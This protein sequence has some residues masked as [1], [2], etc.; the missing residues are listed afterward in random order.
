MNL[1]GVAIK[2]LMQKNEVEPKDLILVYD[3]L[4]LPWGSLRL[5]PDGSAAG[6]NGV[7]DVIDKIGTPA[8]PRVR[9]GVHPG[10]RL[11]QGTGADYLLS[12]FSRQQN[13]TLD[14]FVSL[15]AD[16]TESIIAEGVS[17]SMTRF[18]RRFA[19]GTTE[20]CM[21]IYEKPVHRETRC[22]RRRDRPAHR[23]DVEKHH[24][25]RY[26]TVDKVDKWGKAP[27]CLQSG[28]TPARL[29]VITYVLTFT[30]DSARAVREFGERP[31]ARAEDSVI[32]FP[33]GAHRRNPE[34]HRESGAK[35]FARSAHCGVASRR[36]RSLRL[37]SRCWVADQEES[38]RNPR[39]TGGSGAPRAWRPA[40]GTVCF[41]PPAPEPATTPVAATPQE[42]IRRSHHG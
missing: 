41:L 27:A 9:L 1:S 13:E 25:H 40:S 3:E 7:Q 5:R 42:I 11:V 38:P 8:F 23:T 4:A 30:A 33:D 26:S 14:E 31:Y 12:R 28:E 19:P 21:R 16:A 6:H 32:K 36:P 10:Y 20:G 39:S 34:A 2:S 35:K 24:H 29:K 22:N 18:N 15:A 37:L 17:S